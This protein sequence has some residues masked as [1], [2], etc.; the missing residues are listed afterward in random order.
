MQL[1]ETPIQKRQDETKIGTSQLSKVTVCTESQ[2]WQGPL[3]HGRVSS[4]L[5]ISSVIEAL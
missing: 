1:K 2:C 4:T 5:I 3:P